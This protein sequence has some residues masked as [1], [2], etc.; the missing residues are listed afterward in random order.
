MPTAHD[1]SDPTGLSR[2]LKVRNMFMVSWIPILLFIVA[3]LAVIVCYR[4]RFWRAGPRSYPTR[5]TAAAPQHAA[6]VARNRAESLLMESSLDTPAPIRGAQMQP[7]T[8]KTDLPAVEGADLPASLSTDCRYP[9][10]SLP[11]RQQWAE[12]VIMHLYHLG[13]VERYESF[14]SG[15]TQSGIAQAFGLRQ[16][17]VSNIVRRLVAA[18]V[19]TV[20]TTHVP[21][22]SRRVKVYQ[23]TP[24][25]DSL[26]RRIEH[27]ESYPTG[28]GED[29]S[30][31][32]ANSRFDGQMVDYSDWLAVDYKDTE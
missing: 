8:S 18:G 27:P 29:V 13:V 31:R 15:W 2:A 5:A 10:V 32:T 28:P 3:T 25:G 19:L 11:Q 23:L 1:R 22:F 21:G 20:Q 12:Q 14:S 16:N 17:H 7:R 9:S 30:V 24:L 6:S 4:W 26:A